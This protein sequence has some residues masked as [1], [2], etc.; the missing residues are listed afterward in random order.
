MKSFKQY[1][2][3]AKKKK[4]SFEVL[5]DNK[6]PLEPEEREK[7]MKAGACWHPSNHDKP[8]CAIWKSKDSKGNV[9]YCCHTHRAY[10]A[11]STLDGAIKA[12][13]FIKTTS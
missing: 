7:A 1:T 6:I 3:E 9:K 4:S 8:T 2:T 13:D 12:F 10:Q 5:R 11:K